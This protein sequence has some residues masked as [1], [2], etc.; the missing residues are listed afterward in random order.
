MSRKAGALSGWRA[1]RWRPW[2][3]GPARPSPVCPC[4]RGPAR[5]PAR[6]FRPPAA[7]RPLTAETIFLTSQSINQ[8]RPRA[9][10]LWA[11]VWAPPKICSVSFGFAR[12]KSTLGPVRP[13]IVPFGAAPNCFRWRARLGPVCNQ[14]VGS[15]PAG[16]N[17]RARLVRPVASGAPAKR[18]PAGARARIQINCHRTKARGRFTE[19]GGASGAHLADIWTRLAAT[20]AGP[21]R[22]R[23]RRAGTRPIWWRRPKCRVV[24]RGRAR[25]HY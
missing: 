6:H 20:R 3:R 25:A 24:A 17:G 1:G 14:R 18:R 5:P 9:I 10:V 16:A 4:A 7:S 22:A 13:H 12:T 15:W 23:W 19:L 8:T 11:R 2:A 21:G